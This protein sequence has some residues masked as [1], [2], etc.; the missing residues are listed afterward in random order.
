M[1]SKAVRLGTLPL[2][3]LTVLASSAWGVDLTVE[4]VDLSGLSYD[5]QAPSAV[6]TVSADIKNIGS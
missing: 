5:C 1:C 3:A 4:A 2:V 6:G